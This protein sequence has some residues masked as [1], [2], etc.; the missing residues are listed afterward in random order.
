[1]Q[2]LSVPYHATYRTKLVAFWS[3]D[4]GLPGTLYTWRLCFSGLYRLDIPTSSRKIQGRANLM[5]IQSSF[6][7]KTSPLLRPC[8]IRSAYASRFPRSTNLG[9]DYHVTWL[10]QRSLSTFRIGLATFRIKNWWSL[11]PFTPPQKPNTFSTYLVNLTVSLWLLHGL[12]RWLYT[13]LSSSCKIP[14]P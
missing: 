5:T 13:I 1:M 2:Y 4:F 14:M 8:Y 11:P 6:N 9:H 12:P 10:T 7:R 3:E